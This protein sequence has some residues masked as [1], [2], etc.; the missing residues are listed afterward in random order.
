[1][2]IALDHAV[3]SLTQEHWLRASRLGQLCS[4]LGLVILGQLLKHSQVDTSFNGGVDSG[5]IRASVK[6]ISE[7]DDCQDKAP[8]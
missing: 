3:M 4:R 8:T 5:L 1:V 2:S 6:K 7:G